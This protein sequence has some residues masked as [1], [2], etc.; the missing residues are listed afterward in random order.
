MEMSLSFWLN[1]TVCVASLVAAWV[2]HGETLAAF[3][4]STGRERRAKGMKLILLW[5][6]PVVSLVATLISAQESVSSDKTIRSQ[7]D[8]IADA[9]NRLAIAESEQAIVTNNAAFYDLVGRANSDDRT[10]FDE[11]IAVAHGTN[12]F[13]SLAA[14][15]VRQIVALNNVDQFGGLLDRTRFSLVEPNRVTNR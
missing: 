1:L 4:A 13:K 2:D 3:K 5:G 15:A 14:G 6:V 12:R 8:A 10:A 9:T 7:A 11:L